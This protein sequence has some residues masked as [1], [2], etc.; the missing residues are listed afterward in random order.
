MAEKFNRDID[1]G[2]INKLVASKLWIERLEKDCREGNVFLAIRPGYISFYYKGSGLFEFNKN[3]FQ[4]NLKFFVLQDRTVHNGNYINERD[5]PKA[6]RITKFY[7]SYD[8]IKENCEKYAEK[9]DE[10]VSEIYQRYPYALENSN[11]V[12]LDI[13]VAFIDTLQNDKQNRIDIL[14]FNKKKQKLRFIEAKLYSNQEIKAEN[15]SPKVLKQLQRYRKMIAIKK[16]D[17]LSAYQVYT[18][19]LNG[20]FSGLSLPEPKDIDSNVGLLIFDFDQDQKAGKLDEHVI[21]NKGFIN[22]PFYCRGN[23]KN[24]KA[25]TL[26]KETD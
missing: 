14:L 11:V 3:D 19:T 23:I 25:D 26:W 5:I 7:E 10:G 21:S 16:E 9:E 15:H 24:I 6:K 20:I 13:Q 17:I 18:K 1:T 8:S 2:L 22:I 12:V 4:T